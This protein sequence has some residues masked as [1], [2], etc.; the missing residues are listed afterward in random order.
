[1]GDFNM[2]PGVS[3][4]DIPGNTPE[5]LKEEA[6]W[7]AVDSRM[8]EYFPHLV[9]FINEAFNDQSKPLGDAII[10]YA[11]CA[12]LIEGQ[13]AF[14]QGKLE[15]EMTQ[16]EIEQAIYEQGLMSEAELTHYGKAVR[17]VKAQWRK[18]ENPDT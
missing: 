4:N 11:E 17:E 7:E 1:M 5:D 10:K 15:A 12:R 18:L 8:E 6:F 2:P 9:P 13:D 14:D 16:F 3:V